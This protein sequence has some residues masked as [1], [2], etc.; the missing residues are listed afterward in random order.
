MDLKRQFLAYLEVPNSILVKEKWK[1][2]KKED[3]QCDAG[4]VASSYCA[5]LAG[6]HRLG[7]VGLG[8]VFACLLAFGRRL[9]A[10]RECLLGGLRSLAKHERIE[11]SPS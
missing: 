3:L 11:E 2:K 7:S 10:I 6:Y 1:Q 8:A 4:T 9:G 5:A